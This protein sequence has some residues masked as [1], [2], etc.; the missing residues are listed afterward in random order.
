VDKKV[1][2]G[3]ADKKM[4]ADLFC[5]VFK[6]MEGDVALPKNGQSDVL[7]R[8]GENRKVEEATGSQGGEVKRVERLAEEFAARV[9]ELKFSPAEIISFLLENK[10]SPREAI[11]NV[12]I[13]MT[14]IREERKGAKN[15]A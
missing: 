7:V 13:W 10:Q 5:V 15:E 14:R 6:P 11:D 9:P 12:E 8:S 1:E 3:L 2:L 4:T